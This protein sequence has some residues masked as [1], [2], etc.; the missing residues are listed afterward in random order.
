MKD[1]ICAD[2]G[3]VLGGVRLDNG[4]LLFADNPEFMPTINMTLD[5]GILRF[6]SEN[7]KS[8]NLDVNL[9]SSVNII[10]LLLRK[11]FY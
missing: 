3:A 10:G 1:M 11:S 2:S 8:M 6:R 4:S 9:S 7:K 5:D